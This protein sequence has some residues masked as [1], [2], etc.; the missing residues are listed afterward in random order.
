M[1]YINE[2]VEVFATNTLLTSLWILFLFPLYLVFSNAFASDIPKE[3]YQEVPAI[4][5]PIIEEMEE[6][7]IPDT[8][9]EVKETSI[10]L[11]DITIFE[12]EG[13][14]WEQEETF[15]QA[16]RIARSLLGSNKTFIWHGQL[17]H[18]NYKFELTSLN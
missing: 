5:L 16:F 14:I 11:N 1:K 8:I 7:I 4:E 3:V 13:F 2:E 15:E 6:L 18:T 17:Y 9:D 12:N 10:K